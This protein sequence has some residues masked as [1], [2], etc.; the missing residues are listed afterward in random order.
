[1]EIFHKD[2]DDIKYLKDDKCLL[3]K[4]GNIN[5]K[6]KIIYPPKTKKKINLIFSIPLSIE[7]SDN[8]WFIKVKIC[9]RGG[10]YDLNSIY[11]VDYKY[12]EKVSIKKYTWR[13]IQLIII[14]YIF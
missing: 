3:I 5:N 8:G 6:T 9:F 1:M 14:F 10:F 2:D 11:H 7:S 13:F 12:I 4:N